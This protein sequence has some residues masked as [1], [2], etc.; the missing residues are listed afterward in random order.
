MQIEVRKV[1]PREIDISCPHGVM[2]MVKWN[3]IRKD[4]IKHQKLH[5]VMYVPSFGDKPV[6]HDAALCFTCWVLLLPRLALVQLY[7]IFY[8]FQRGGGERKR[9]RC[10]REGREREL[11]GRMLLSTT[12]VYERVIMRKGCCWEPQ[13][14]TAAFFITI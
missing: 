1:G 11:A 2:D 8:L 14:A 3:E 13:L 4:K 10:G 9:L 6:H 5:V 12:R 7:S